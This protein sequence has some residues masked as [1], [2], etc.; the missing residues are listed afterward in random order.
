MLHLCLVLMSIMAADDTHSGNSGPTL[1]VV[2]YNIHGFGPVAAHDSGRVAL[3]RMMGRKQLIRRL[4]LELSLYRP[5]VISVQEA[6]SEARTQELARALDMHMAY[7]P[8]GWKGKGWPEGISGAIL[9]RFPIIE[10]E[11]CPREAGSE[12]PEKIFSRHFGRA[13]IDVDGTTVAVYSAHL[14]P[15][16]ENTTSIRLSEIGGIV[17]TLKGD[18]EAGRSVI[19]LGDMNHAPDTPE[20]RAWL[21]AGFIDS[22]AAK[23]KGTPLTCPS[24]APRERIDYVFV[25]GPLSSRLKECRVLYEGAFRVSADDL[26]SYALS[27]HLPVLAIFGD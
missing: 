12:R 8:G 26:S 6:H 16:W 21:E 9:S 1:R 18:R 22:F 3:R 23:G 13:L 15:S 10:V 27:D 17:R 25:A 2:T 24:I 19:V 11:D 20:H 7:F 4:A 5:D 14:L